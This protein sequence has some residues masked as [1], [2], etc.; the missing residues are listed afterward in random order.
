MPA[1][2]GGVVTPAERP[3][4]LVLATR[5]PGKVRE[6]LALLE[7][8]RL[9]LQVLSL[10]DFPACPAV[11]ETGATFADNACLKAR[12]VADYAGL[13]ALADDSGLE[14]PA[15][16]GAPGVR[17]HRFAGE[18]ASDADNNALLLQRMA[19]LAGPQRRARFVAAV[20]LAVPQPARFVPR[21]AGR[22]GEPAP[23]GDRAEDAGAGGCRVFYGQCWGTIATEP[24]GEGG[25]GYDPLFVP[26]EGDG[27]AFAEMSAREKSR[28]SHR[29]RAL[30]EVV[31]YL[32]S[33]GRW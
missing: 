15:L 30:R 23:A 22:A 11:E 12:I 24:R 1:K 28:L 2:T 7:E 18:D 26:D 16:G 3:K 14:V 5:N 21:P 8:A 4:A 33:S 13:W 32:R 10:R 27:R 9:P 19:G 25:F 31:D 6:L 20:A 17:S 29:G